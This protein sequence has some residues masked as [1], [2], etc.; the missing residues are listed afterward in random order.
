MWPDLHI[1]VYSASGL[2]TGYV[3]EAARKGLVYTSKRQS[4]SSRW[5]R[6]G[7]PQCHVLLQTAEANTGFHCNFKSLP[8]LASFYVTCIFE[9]MLPYGGEVLL[10]QLKIKMYSFHIR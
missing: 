3:S 10:Q 6:Q 5:R 1:R 9:D 4:H 7:N 2:E 8:R